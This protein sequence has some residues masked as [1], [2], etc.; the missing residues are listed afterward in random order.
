M[1]AQE[2]AANAAVNAY[3]AMDQ[4]LRIACLALIANTC[5]H[6]TTFSQIMI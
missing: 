6:Q 3:P 5:T 1:K 2:S 4:L